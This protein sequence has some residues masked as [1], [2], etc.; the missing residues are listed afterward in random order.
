VARK[1]KD[2]PELKAELKAGSLHLSNARR[3]API[4]NSENKTVWTEK[5]K[6]LPQRKLEQELA[7]EFPRL[8]TQEKTTYVSQ[9]RLELKLGLNQATLDKLKRMQDLL[10]QKESKAASYEDCLNAALD[11]Y[12]QRHD[13]IEKAKRHAEKNIE[14]ARRATSGPSKIEPQPPINDTQR[15]QLPAAI[16]HQIT[17]RDGARCGYVDL[18]GKRCDERRWLDLHHINPR[19][20]GGADTVGNLITMCKGHHRVAHG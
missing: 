11:E 4:L 6:T 8:A 12:L 10:S 3:I 19:S 16:K 17:L 2:I 5:A 13:P 9:D 18:F 7:A 1:S 20:N 14:S 15:Q